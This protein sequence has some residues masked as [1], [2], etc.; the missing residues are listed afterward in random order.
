[1]RSILHSGNIEAPLVGLEIVH[2]EESVVKDSP[3]EKYLDIL[4]DKSLWLRC[5]YSKDKPAIT[6][7][8]LF[9]FRKQDNLLVIH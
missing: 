3:G 6:E 5:Y 1:M 7:I 4:G 9:Y 2:K 8:G